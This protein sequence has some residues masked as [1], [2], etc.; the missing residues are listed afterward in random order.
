MWCCGRR[1]RRQR[2][3]RRSDVQRS[4]SE[5]QSRRGGGAAAERSG[6]NARA[7]QQRGLL[8][9][10]S[11][12]RAC[13][14]RPP[15]R[16][17]QRC[18]AGV[19]RQ[20]KRHGRAG[21]ISRAAA[22]MRDVPSGVYTVHRWLRGWLVLLARRGN[23]GH[24]IQGEGYVSHESLLSVHISSRS[25]SVFAKTPPLRSRGPRASL[26]CP[27]FVAESWRKSTVRQTALTHVCAFVQ[28]RPSFREDWRWRSARWAC[29]TTPS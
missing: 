14:P 5:R 6:A 23:G 25:D 3:T 27:H 24:H 12:R 20:E 16:G 10:P 11:A 22:P 9:E 8:A 1:A 19:E 21:S 2:G 15:K 29:R 28:S 13:E 4:A 26:W 7:A 18:T 17:G